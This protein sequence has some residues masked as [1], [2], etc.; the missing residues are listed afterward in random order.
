VR[1]T[2]REGGKDGR[3]ESEATRTRKREREREF[4]YD[5]GEKNA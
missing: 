5:S 1:D 4:L 3:K 2:Q